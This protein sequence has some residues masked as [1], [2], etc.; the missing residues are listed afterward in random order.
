[1]RA[2]ASDVTDDCFPRH[3]VLELTIE[4]ATERSCDPAPLLR[5]VQSGS[6]VMGA[7][8]AGA[9]YSPGFPVRLL[10]EMSGVILPRISA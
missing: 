5:F 3:D 1:M 9:A 4:L 10:A 7:V 8:V 6:M 2:P